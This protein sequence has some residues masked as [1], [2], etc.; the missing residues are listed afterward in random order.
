MLRFKAKADGNHQKWKKAEQKPSRAESW[1]HYFPPQLDVKVR[2]KNLAQFI[3][4][5]TQH[6]LDAKPEITQHRHKLRVDK[7]VDMI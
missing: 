1:Q 2:T 4:N 5:V 6:H 7:S 3:L